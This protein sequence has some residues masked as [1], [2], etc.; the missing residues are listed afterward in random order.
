MNK[1]TLVMKETNANNV[2]VYTMEVPCCHAIHMMTMKA[3]KNAGKTNLNT[4]YFIVG[5]A[6]GR[7]EPYRLGR[8]DSSMIEAEKKAHGHLL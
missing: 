6:S 2:E 3:I 7:I 4:K 5:V 1:L 8:I